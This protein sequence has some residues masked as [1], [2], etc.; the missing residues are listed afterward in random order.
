MANHEHL[1]QRFGICCEKQNQPATKTK[2]I[3]HFMGLDLGLTP[4]M[5]PG[6]L[7]VAV[8]P[9]SCCP[10]LLFDRGLRKRLIMLVVM[11]LITARQI[12]L[13]DGCTNGLS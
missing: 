4:A 9:K 1:K 8:S 3:D 5:S 10:W 11:V 2:P 6:T 13:N 7:K 12:M